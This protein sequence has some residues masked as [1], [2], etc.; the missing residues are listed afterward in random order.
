MTARSDKDESNFV[1]L[2]EYSN[3]III[4]IGFYVVV[5]VSALL[6]SLQVLEPVRITIM[7]VNVLFASVRKVY[8]DV[9][10]FLPP[11]LLN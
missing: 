6:P 4:S 11:P 10:I 1:I 7:T 9:E 2:V 3:E 8:E 5:R